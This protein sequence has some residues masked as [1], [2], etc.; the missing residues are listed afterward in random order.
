MEMDRV[1]P[2]AHQFGI[3]VRS[4]SAW[5]S[6]CGVAG[7]RRRGMVGGKYP[8]HHEDHANVA[9]SGLL[10]GAGVTGVITAMISM[11]RG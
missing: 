1:S 8:A 10:A 9:A 7:L 3:G 4:S 2:V 6:P 11:A 5:S